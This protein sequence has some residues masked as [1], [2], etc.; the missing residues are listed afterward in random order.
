MPVHGRR[1]ECAR[2]HAGPERK[3]G[4]PERQVLDWA[5]TDESSGTET[6]R[7]QLTERLRFARAENTVVL[8]TMDCLA[9]NLDGLGTLAE[10][11]RRKACL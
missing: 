9:R 8:H 6:D 4:Q 1:A 2:E 3:R 5:F 10:G 11:L 7:P